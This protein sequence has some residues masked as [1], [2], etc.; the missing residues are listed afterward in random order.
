MAGACLRRVFVA[1]HAGF[2]QDPGRIAADTKLDLTVDPWGFLGRS[3]HLW[4]PQ[5]FFGQLQNQAYGH[6]WPMGPFFG[7]GDSLGLPAWVVQR[8]WWSLILGHGVPGH[9][10]AP[11][12]YG[13]GRG[14]RR[15]W[16]DSPT[17]WQ[18]VPSRRSRPYRSRC[19]PWHWRR[20]SCCR[21]CAA[22]PVGNVA[23]AAALSALMVML[24][25]GVNAVAA[26]AV[27]P[28]A[29]W[30]L[31][32]LQPGPGVANCWRGGPDSPC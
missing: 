3:L 12:H 6:L 7:I 10:S 8:L 1:G 27:L 20:G 13:S 24:A 32:T 11:A 9:V 14:G 15:S 18:F 4:D 28:L 31:L 16:P 23:R 5:G 25:G 17:P 26:G 19:G 29:L 22:L 30:W 21:W 2:L